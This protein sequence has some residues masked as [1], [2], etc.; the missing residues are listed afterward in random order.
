MP[1]FFGKGEASTQRAGR[2]CRLSQNGPSP[3][4]FL[5]DALLGLRTG[6]GPGVLWDARRSLSQCA[7]YSYANTG[8]NRFNDGDYGYREAACGDAR[9]QSTR[10]RN[11]AF[12]TAGIA[13]HKPRQCGFHV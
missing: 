1:K 4:L 12:A 6:K 7:G 3:R 9:D 13:A 10:S 5:A 8:K 2:A 11:M